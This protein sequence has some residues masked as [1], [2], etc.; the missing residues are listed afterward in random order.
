MAEKQ[1]SLPFPEIAPADPAP[2]LQL[3]TPDDIFEAADKYVAFL[4]EDRRIERKPGGIH[5]QSLG[6]YFSMWANTSPEGG[7]I[8]IG[9][10]DKGT[11]SGLRTLDGKVL[12]EL[13]KTG[14]DRCPQ[15]VFDTK[16]VGL[17]NA[18]GEND[19]VLLIRVKYHPTR[20]VETCDG[21]VFRRIGDSKVEVKKDEEKR[22]MRL[23]KGEIQNEQEPVT[24]A[25]P[26][27]FDTS[28]IGKWAATIR[29][30]R[31]ITDT[32]SDEKILEVMRLGKRKGDRF[33][34]NLACALLF[35]HD[36]KS[37]VPGCHIRFLRFEGTVEGTGP[38]WNAVQDEGITGPLPRQI[39]Q[40]SRVVASQIRKF[41][42][43]KD[44]RFQTSAEY[45]ETAWYEAVVNACVH[46]SY[47]LQNMNIFIKMFNDRLEID[48]PGPF[49]PSVT[50]E[51]IF[52]VQHSRN[53]FL[54]E[55]MR[56]L[57]FVK[58]VGEG[59]RRMR[60]TMLQMDLPA[61]RFSQ[62]EV[63]G[64]K[65]RVT[66]INNFA[67]RK[68]WVDEDVAQLIGAR[69]ASSLS[70]KEK[71]ILSFVAVHKSINISEA[72]TLTKHSWRKA[73]DILERLVS[74]GILQY[75]KQAGVEKDVKAHYKLRVEVGDLPS[76]GK[77][78]KKPS[79]LTH[80]FLVGLEEIVNT[81]S[82]H[83]AAWPRMVSKRDVSGLRQYLYE[84][85]EA[86]VEFQK[87]CSADPARPLADYIGPL[88]M[89][90]HMPAETE[91]QKTD[92]IEAASFCRDR[93]RHAIASMLGS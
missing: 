24:L 10:E 20:L 31:K 7:L 9:I 91:K 4:K 13:E 93:L 57:D 14:Y 86:C 19:F 77:R 25:Y 26:D 63:G 76:V 40:A 64:A 1:P 44:N 50:P 72:Q 70:E 30:E 5:S 82:R 61:P 55:A 35:A 68:V 81:I 11:V 46:R 15:A 84:L 60:D 37:V 65:V 51:N 54:M 88:L 80:P 21:K 89:C 45:P 48:S 32:V 83:A 79:N 90:R 59:T 22:Q 28:L 29:K 23:D 38:T 12:N 43:M 27:D 36:P 33:V 42:G 66:L 39:E 73:K 6:E 2:V 74:L 78:S 87:T 69:I 67:G 71:E 92:F 85:C 62:V 17:L 3:L 8:V 58:C 53:P 41:S 47:N 75:V 16:R 18:T 49:P 52:E 56:H 34:P